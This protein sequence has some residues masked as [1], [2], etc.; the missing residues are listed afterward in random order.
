MCFVGGIFKRT[1]IL[2]N[3]SY[4]D[5]RVSFVSLIQIFKSPFCNTFFFLLLNQPE[6]V[7]EKLGCADQFIGDV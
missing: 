3:T 7:G 4:Q 5:K 1:V 6:E 2:D